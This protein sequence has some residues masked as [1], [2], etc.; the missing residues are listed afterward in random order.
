[1]ETRISKTINTKIGSMLLLASILGVWIATYGVVQYGM[2]SN[3]SIGSLGVIGALVILQVSILTV[4]MSYSSSSLLVW[5]K[6]TIVIYFASILIMPLCVGVIAY[7][8]WYTFT[9]TK[10]VKS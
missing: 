5:N 9:K 2:W 3:F 4:V 1:M 7:H 8:T 10:R 6:K